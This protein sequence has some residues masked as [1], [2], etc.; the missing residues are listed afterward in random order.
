MPTARAKLS[1]LI[2]GLLEGT[3]DIGTV[4]HAVPWG[5]TYNLT[6]GTGADNINEIFADTRQLA[7]STAENLDLAGVLTDVFNNVITFTKIKFIIVKAAATNTNDVMVGGHA[8]AACFSMFNAATDKLRIKPG[9]FVVLVAP[10][11]VGFAVT[12]TTA[13]ML[14]VGNSSSG[15]VVDYDII[16]G[17]TV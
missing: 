3:A 6:T 15:S 11:S 8:S 9:G 7:A 1:F 4:Q 10:N 2:D 17:G 14:T 5:A 13:D 16:I 12:A